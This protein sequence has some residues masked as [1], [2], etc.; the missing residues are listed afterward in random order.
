ML[1]HYFKGKISRGFI[2]TYSAR[3][4]IQAAGALVGLFLPIF[5]Y[6]FFN[7]NLQYVLWYYLIGHF[8]YATIV[9]CGCKFLNK[10]GL[11]RSI[12]IS[13]FW[14]ALFYFCFYLMSNENLS[15]SVNGKYMLGLLLAS[16]LFLTLL[17]SMYW[18]P[19]HTNLAKFTNKSNRAKQLSL[20]SATAIVL[21]TFM[22]LLAGWILITHGFNVLFLITIIIYLLSLIPLI[23]SPRT[24]EKFSWTYMQTWKELLSKKRRRVVMAYFGDGAETAVGAVI[25]P[26]FIWQLLKGNYFQ[27]GVISALIVVVTVLLQLAIGKFTD[28]S[29]KS[30]ILKFS[31]VFYALGWVVKIF[32]FTAFQIFVVSAYHGLMKLFTR[33]VF[34]TMYYQ[35]SADQG[36]YVDE[37]TV[38]HEMA[39]Q[40]GKTLMLLFISILVMFFGMQWSFIL[41]AIASLL[42]NFLSKDEELQQIK[43]RVS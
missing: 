36:H 3:M 4:V 30:K 23:T 41:A 19:L 14:G 6:N 35:D 27:V 26:I 21:S 16:I 12:I 10:I 38:I 20:M 40:Y 1:F 43:K 22:P 24:N 8:I 33:T 37:Y 15:W 32:I 2:A 7:F 17:R 28:L 25:W 42:L 9:A 39:I 5:L 29:N 31:S 34:D 13:V 11:R 18:V